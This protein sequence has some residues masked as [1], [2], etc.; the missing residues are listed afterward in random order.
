LDIGSPVHPKLR[1][2]KPAGSM[3]SGNPVVS[4]RTGAKGPYV[5]GDV[6]RR[7]DP[8][9]ASTRETKAVN[10]IAAVAVAVAALF[11]NTRRSIR[12]PDTRT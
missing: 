6:F 1:Y 10:G 12:P 8:D 5:V 2:V 9:D 4:S 7:C 3:R 11:K